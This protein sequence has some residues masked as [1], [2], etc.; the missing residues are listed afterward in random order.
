MEGDL[1]VY[2]RGM[3]E[4]HKPDSQQLAKAEVCKIA[5]TIVEARSNGPFLGPCHSSRPLFALSC[6]KLGV[7]SGL[8]RQVIELALAGKQEGANRITE[9]QDIAL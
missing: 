2:S 9:Q 3:R 6:L 4:C 8:A 1:Q 5:S 7:I